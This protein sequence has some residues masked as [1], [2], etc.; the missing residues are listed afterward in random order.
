MHVALVAGAADDRAVDPAAL[1][2]ARTELT[3]WAAGLG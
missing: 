3:A 2:A 1:A